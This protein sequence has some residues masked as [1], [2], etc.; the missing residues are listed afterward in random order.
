MPVL[1]LSP[2]SGGEAAPLRPVQIFR[3][4]ALWDSTIRDR[5]RMDSLMLFLVV[6]WV[7]LTLALGNEEGNPWLVGTWSAVK[8]GRAPDPLL[9]SFVWIACLLVGYEASAF[10]FDGPGSPAGS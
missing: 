6:S 9:L 5:G 10:G 1:W 4:S 3:V 2:T 7:A 8:R